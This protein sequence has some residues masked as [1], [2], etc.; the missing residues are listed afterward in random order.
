MSVSP[1]DT[2]EY[3]VVVHRAPDGQVWLE[4]LRVLGRAAE[5]SGRLAGYGGRLAGRG[6][7]AGLIRLRAY[8]R[9]PEGRQA[10]TRGV[11]ALAVA[12]VILGGAGLVRDW[13]ASARRRM[14][15]AA[16][17]FRATFGAMGAAARAARFVLPLPALARFLRWSSL[18]GTFRLHQP[19]PECHSRIR[20]EARVCY[21]C[22]HRC[23]GTEPRDA[24]GLLRAGR[25]GVRWLWRVA[26]LRLYRG[27]PDCRRRVHADARVCR[28]C[29]YRLR[30]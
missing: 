9:T 18:A 3:E 8:L 1:G 30:G 17:G 20:S 11:K 24:R 27:C 15:A 5:R 6:G 4:R 26:A 16:A 12:A 19:C 25:T 10:A 22:G 13:L 2:G 21:R 29:G 28:H 14:A 23:S 7:R